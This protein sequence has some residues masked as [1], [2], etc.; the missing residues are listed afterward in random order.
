MKV[1]VRVY[2]LLKEDDAID[3]EKEC[4]V[5]F[6]SYNGETELWIDFG[7]LPEFQSRPMGMIRV[8]MNKKELEELIK[9]ILKKREKA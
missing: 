3:F 7:N 6:Y 5:S 4:R 2:G 9:E 8:K 1:H